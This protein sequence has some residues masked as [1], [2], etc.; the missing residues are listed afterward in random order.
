MGGERSFF[1]AYV[2]RLRLLGGDSAAARRWASE[3][4]PWQPD[5]PHSYFREI[6]LLTIARVVILAESTPIENARL[7]ETLAMLTWLREQALAAGRGAVVIEALALAALAHAGSG[8]REQAHEL[9]N[10][11]LMLAAP[12]GFVGIF[13]DLGAPLAGLLAH[14]AKRKAQSDSL[15]AYM[16][17]LLAAFRH[18]SSADP[19]LEQAGQPALRP[20]FE[21]SNALQEALTEREVEVLR[22]FAAGMTSPEIAQ[23]F[24]VSINTVKTQ[25]K[26]IYSKLDA[27]SRAE[28]VGR[29]R[30]LGLIS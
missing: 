16:Q 23:H 13:V 10:T 4:R 5:E 6:E 24:V 27:H 7:E 15:Q 22:L 26:S 1:G 8:A 30:E 20:A 19:T 29:A 25:L 2:A 21:R 11:A 3:R 28:A 18:T 12:E 9:L 14:S 17:R